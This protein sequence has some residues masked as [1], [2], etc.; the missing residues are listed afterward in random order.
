MGAK[1]EIL[2]KEEL[3]KSC[4]LCVQFCA[5]GCIAITGDKISPQGFAVP[6]SVH[7]EKCIGCGICGWMCPDLAIA[8]YKLTENEP[9][10]G[11]S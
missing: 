1:G 6:S 8:V 10:V 3:C 11:I 4:G 5:K 7:P 2:I 9:A